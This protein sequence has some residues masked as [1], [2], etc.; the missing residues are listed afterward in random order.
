MAQQRPSSAAT[1]TKK[2]QQRRPWSGNTLSSAKYTQR[3][4]Y[5][6]SS[7]RPQR[8]ISPSIQTSQLLIPNTNSSGGVQ[9]LH[10]DRGNQQGSITKQVIQVASGG[11]R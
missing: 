9:L 7:T 5:A 2:T 1:S 6:G 10:F 3:S 8:P 11:A 4:S